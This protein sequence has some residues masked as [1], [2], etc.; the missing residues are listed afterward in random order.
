MPALTQSWSWVRRADTEIIPHVPTLALPTHL[1][2]TSTL[3]PWGPDVSSLK[4]YHAS[5]T[6]TCHR[7]FKAADKSNDIIHLLPGP[8]L[9][10]SQGPSAPAED[11]SQPLGSPGTPSVW[12]N[13]FAALMLNFLVLILVKL[14]QLPG[15]WRFLFPQRHSRGQGAEEGRPLPAPWAEERGVALPS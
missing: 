13:S 2:I 6:S 14:F 5:C 1:L 15:E 7:R 4:S 8:S 10:W 11:V 12:P 9:A 3:G